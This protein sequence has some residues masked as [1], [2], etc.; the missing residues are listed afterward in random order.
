[1]GMAGP[2]IVL[3][4]VGFVLFAGAG[5][6]LVAQGDLGGGSSPTNAYSVLYPLSKVEA[7]KANV[8][9]FGSASPTIP[10]TL[11]NVTKVT[12]TLACNDAVPGGTFN[13]QVNIEPPNGIAPVSKG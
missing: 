12:V 7:G 8:P 10:V 5:Y 1:M 3:F 9:D 11:G 13:L 2:D 4:V 6:A